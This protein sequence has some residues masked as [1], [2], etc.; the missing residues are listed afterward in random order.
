[1]SDCHK[2]RSSLS[3]TCS[4]MLAL[5]LLCSSCPPDARAWAFQ[6]NRGGA[7]DTRHGRRPKS[8]TG[9]RRGT[10]N[11]TTRPR[12]RA[13]PAL[14]IMSSFAGTTL[15][16]FVP[17]GGRVR[18]VLRLANVPSVRAAPPQ[19]FAA[20]FPRSMLVRSIHGPS[21][22]S[23]K[24]VVAA[25]AVAGDKRAGV[26]SVDAGKSFGALG[27]SEELTNAVSRGAERLVSVKGWRQEL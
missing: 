20:A 15:R 1:M 26:A 19:C 22:Q 17:L 6:N 21:Q 9:R 16:S 18:A 4:G 7:A 24:R 2:G 14:F 13:L 12:R 23:R 27:L 10:A 11:E 25:A 8:K 5:L 3:S